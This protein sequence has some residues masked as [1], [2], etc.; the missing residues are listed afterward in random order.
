[1]ANWAASN[2]NTM[3][4]AAEHSYDPGEAILGTEDGL[5]LNGLTL[6]SDKVIDK[7]GFAVSA[8]EYN[9][10]GVSRVIIAFRGTDDL[11][12]G[13]ADAG[14]VGAETR[15]GLFWDS[16]KLGDV[17][18]PLPPT[19]SDITKKAEIVFDSYLDKAQD[20]S[21]A[22]IEEYGAENI[23]FTGHS[24]GGAIAQIEAARTGLPAHTFEAPGVQNYIEKHFP[25]ADGSVVWNHF[26]EGDLVSK[27][28]SHFG[29]EYVY[30]SYSGWEE[31]TK[32][33]IENLIDEHRI[34]NIAEEVL[35]GSFSLTQQQ[36][37]EWCPPE[38]GLVADDFSSFLVSNTV[39][40]A[41]QRAINARQ[42]AQTAEQVSTEAEERVASAVDRTQE[43]A[44]QAG[45]SAYET[46]AV[47]ART[48]SASQIVEEQAAFAAESAASS[49]DSLEDLKLASS[50]AEQSART[51]K[52]N[53][54]SAE[55]I[56][57]ATEGYSTSA[58]A[59][60]EASQANAEK[61]E[62]TLQQSA[63]FQE[64]AQVSSQEAKEKSV[65]AEVDAA[66]AESS[67]V[68]VSVAENTTNES[69]QE[70]N[71]AASQVSDIAHM[72][73]AW[74]T[75]TT[76]AVMQSDNAA[77]SA[78]IARAKA[79]QAKE[80]ADEARVTA[81]NESK[82][83]LSNEGTAREAYGKVDDAKT[84]ADSAQAEVDQFV[85]QTVEMSQQAS[86][87][88]QR[89]DVG[90]VTANALM[91][92]SRSSVMAAQNLATEIEEVKTSID[93]I[94]GQIEDLANQ[95][96]ETTNRVTELVESIS[97]NYQICDGALKNV[98]N[99][100]SQIQE[101]LG[102]TRDLLNDIQSMQ[103]QSLAAIEEIQT[104]SKETQQ[105]QSECSHLLQDAYEHRVHAD[106]SVGNIAVLAERVQAYAEDASSAAIRAESY[107]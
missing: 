48:A 33:T 21:D 44:D 60:A 20:F 53:L 22:L 45:Q 67:K 97:T 84:R 30:E 3:L 34:K 85:A 39:S 104:C 61:A 62:Q 56:K 40:A 38:G 9:D 52:E 11:A 57:S 95:N 37:T 79:D 35:D 83:A 54:G 10:G 27:V 106:R 5:S 16:I 90:L 18:A 65:G 6:L 105:V 88:S 26:R 86:V 59:A 14:L 42:V 100:A 15:D 41:Q 101:R 77:S 68:K 72:S 43:G 89:L 107:I 2:R 7:S 70:T 102:S 4:M 36:P 31:G 93:S 8:Y 19:I 87:E 76:E 63:Q 24:L 91:T 94:A 103:E 80:S 73:Q 82:S 98:S 29:H 32:S 75:E 25:D 78:E 1:M 13:I 96:L 99:H 47:Q 23:A 71:E 51:T 69:R 64:E 50:D 92:Q 17:D 66:L 58:V 46:F 12:D 49:Q 55:Q 81:V 28:S 74:A